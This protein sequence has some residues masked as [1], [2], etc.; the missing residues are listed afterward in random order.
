VDWDQWGNR[1]RVR[2]F[3]GN[4]EWGS[5]NTG[6]RA[7]REVAREITETYY[8]KQNRPARG[9]RLY[10]DFREMLERESD[11]Q[12]VINITPDHQHGCVNVAALRKNKAALSHKPVASVLYELRRVLDASKASRAPSHLL[13]TIR[14]GTRSRHGSS[15]A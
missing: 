11:I 7:G 8:Q 3:I 4:A 13:A 14:T 5:G 12:G 1:R 6:I 10:E 9:I 15:P 2:D